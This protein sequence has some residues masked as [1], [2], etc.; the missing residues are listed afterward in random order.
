MKIILTIFFLNLWS[1]VLAQNNHFI[2]YQDTIGKVYFNIRQE[3]LRLIEGCYFP[4]S[5]IIDS[6]IYNGVTP[7]R[8]K[9]SHIFNDR[10]KRLTYQKKFSKPIPVSDNCFYKDRIYS[11]NIEEYTVYMIDSAGTVL[12][13]SFRIS[14]EKYQLPNEIP[15]QK[16][17]SSQNKLLLNIK[18]IV[19]TASKKKEKKK[20][21]FIVGD[22]LLYN[23]EGYYKEDIAHPFFCKFNQ[24]TYSPPCI[25]SDMSDYIL[26]S[27][28]S[29]HDASI[30]IFPPI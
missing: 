3:G 9:R 2:F 22:L 7:L 12:E 21:R 17:K 15:L 25:T 29:Y 11:E 13:K 26:T 27:S 5:D 19:V 18:E 16:W 20:C 1:I 23:K 28:M 10:D 4:E 14:K 24:K 30:N 6:T 8:M